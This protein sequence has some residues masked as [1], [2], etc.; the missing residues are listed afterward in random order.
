MHTDDSR[1]ARRDHPPDGGRIQIVRRR[2]D[3]GEDRRDLL[4]LQRVRRRDERVRRN[5][6][7][8]LQIQRARSDFQRDR[9]VAH[10]D[11][12]FDAKKRR[13]SLLEL[14]GDRPIVRKPATIEDVGRALKK[15]LVVADIRTA[16][17]KRLRKHRRRAVDGKIGR[18]PD[19]FVRR[20]VD[21]FDE[22][23]GYALGVASPPLLWRL[24]ISSARCSQT[25]RCL[26][27]FHGSPLPQRKMPEPQVQAQV[28]PIFPWA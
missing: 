7:L 26:F 23:H 18:C 9:A 17:V 19:R 4:P 21:V 24:L 15:A 16:D 2:V 14:L 11:A 5:D 20:S 1:G 13:D 25:R 3:V 10:R 6:D 8:A 12:M 22:F 27:G 28:G